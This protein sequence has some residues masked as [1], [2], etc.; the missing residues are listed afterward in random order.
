MQPFPAAALAAVLA[1]ALGAAALAA[2]DGAGVEPLLEQADNA[3]TPA[4]A[5]TSSLR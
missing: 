5:S 4:D 2:A 3:I 1:A